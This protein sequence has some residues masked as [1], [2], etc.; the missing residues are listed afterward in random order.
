[1]AD[2]ILT[3]ALVFTMDAQLRA[4]Q[5]GYV[6]MRDDRIHAVG[7][8]ADLQATAGATVRSMGGRHLVMPGLINA[9]DHISN[10]VV[11]GSFDEGSREDYGTRMYDA[12]RAMDGDASYAGAMGSILEQLLGGVTTT[13]A[14]EFGHVDRPAGVLRA[15]RESGI[16]T[17]FSLAVMN[18]D[19]DTVNSQAV[20]EDFR[21]SPQSAVARM[22]ALDREFTSPTIT[23][24][25]EALSPMRVTPDMLGALHEYARSRDVPLFM[26]LGAAQDELDECER[27]FGMGT[28]EFLERRGWLSPKTVLAHAAH[29]KQ[30]DIAIIAQHDAAIAHCPVASSWA[31]SSPPM[32]IEWLEAG[33]RV[34]VGTDGASSNN[35]QNMWESGKLAVLLQRTRNRNRQYGSAELGLELMTSRAARSIYMEDRIGSI[36]PGKLADLICIDMDRPALTPRE[37]INSNLLFSNDRDAVRHVYVGGKELVRDGAPTTIDYERVIALNK[38]QGRLLLREKGLASSFFGRSRFTWI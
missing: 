36:E 7:A 15:C 31:G 4:F 20:P 8:M 14:G 12:L 35:S 5:N 17:V 6:W 9:H 13:Q 22:Q 16:R 1:M 24:A 29:I 32:L 18:S 33:I 34:G 26:H 38:E 28:I 19:D 10:N 23:I 2:V 21:E 30:T 37:T 27:R 11:R 3:N 25:P